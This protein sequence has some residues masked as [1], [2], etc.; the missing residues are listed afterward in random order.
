MRAYCVGHDAA[1]ADL[2]IPALRIRFWPARPKRH[3]SAA[4]CLRA[5]RLSAPL[6]ADTRWKFS[7]ACYWNDL[8]PRK[9]AV[10][11]IISLI[12]GVH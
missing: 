5:V 11:L 9:Y 8:Q 2:G 4:V 7:V 3:H 1:L 12:C 10:R 6:D